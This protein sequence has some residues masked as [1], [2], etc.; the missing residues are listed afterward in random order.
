MQFQFKNDLIYDI[1]LERIRSGVYPIGM[2][3]PPE[4]DFARELQV[5]KV[6]L[7]SALAR[8]EHERMIV[9]MRAK[10]TFIARRERESVNKLAVAISSKLEPGGPVPYILSLLLKAAE[11]RGIVLEQIDAMLCETLP[12]NL[13]KQ[14]FRDKAVEGILL[15]TSN[16][17]GGEP[18]VKRLR[19]LNLPVVL[20]HGDIGDAGS[21][22]FG[23]VTVDQRKAFDE[24]LQYVLDKPFKRVAILGRLA[25]DRKLARGF[26]PDE[27]RSRVGERLCALFYEPYDLDAIGTRVREF[28]RNPA[29][30]PDVFIC[31]S[32]LYAIFLLSVLK[33]LKLR[34]PE[35]VSVIGFSGL[36][37]DF[38][39][40]M[41]L[42]GVK[43]RYAEMVEKS[44]DMMAN[45]E[46]WFNIDG[47]YEP[48]EIR[49]PYDFIQGDSV[50]L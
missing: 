3:L 13:L 17:T 27:L 1:L 24:T 46:Q 5:G 48:P 29:V 42:T 37:C 30:A 36:N 38:H 8:L 7:R 14:L 33:Q 9:R 23:N 16:F 34:V 41:E 4:P 50:C 15:P 49:V 45:H 39:I 22:G 20:P 25:E 2:K 19:V 31:F 43:Y 6:T 32:D 40:R 35:D 12:E 11:R 21:T 18:L 10:G 47:E 26:S 44:L 28:Y